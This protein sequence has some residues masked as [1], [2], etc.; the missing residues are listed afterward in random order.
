MKATVGVPSHVLGLNILIQ[1]G[2]QVSNLLLGATKYNLLIVCIHDSEDQGTFI[3]QI[4]QDS[5][6]GF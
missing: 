5:M 2:T 3:K 1:R 6:T 4:L